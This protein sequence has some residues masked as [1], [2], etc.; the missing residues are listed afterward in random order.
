MS[1]TLTLSRFYSGKC[2]LGVLTDEQNEIVCYTLE[3]PWEDNARN[4][5]CIPDGDYEVVPYSSAKYQHS[6]EILDVPGRDAIL[7]HQG[8][9][10]KDTLGCILVG[11][12]LGKLGMDNAALKSRDKLDSMV[13]KYFNGFNLKIITVR[14]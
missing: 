3:N 8:N 6:F 1:V 9:T 7:I 4:V 2:T 10:I 12:S 14:R 13:L 5:S 11:E